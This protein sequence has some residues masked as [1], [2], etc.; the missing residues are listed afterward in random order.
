MERSN[1]Y[2]TAVD[3]SKNFQC[4]KCMHRGT[5]PYPAVSF[6]HKFSNIESVSPLKLLKEELFCYHSREKLPQITLGIGVSLSHLAR[7]GEIK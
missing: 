3:N 6:L 1:Q 4:T 7:T 2:R 5:E